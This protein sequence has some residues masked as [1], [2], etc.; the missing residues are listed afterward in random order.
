MSLEIARRIGHRE[1]TSLALAGQ[2]RLLRACG[3]AAGARRVHEEMLETARDLGTSLWT[4]D[5]YGNLGE[6]LLQAG[7]GEATARYIEAAIAN[8]GD[9]MK[10]ALRPLIAQAELHLRAGRAED[11]VAAARHVAALAPEMRVFVADAR[12]VEGEALARLGR[13]EEAITVLADARAIV[14]AI[15]ALPGQWRI[16]LALAGLL[17][18]CGRPDQ[19]RD[20]AAE[21][22]AALQRT[23]RDISDPALRR[24]FQDSN[25]WRE[26]TKKSGRPQEPV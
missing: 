24:R 20:A 2:G 26:A 9:C 17:D 11:A 21:A 23:A 8:A 7:D 5:A 10:Y 15:G 16:G 3:D 6:D 1:W 12:C 4:A 18:R 14:A 19:A 13:L 22:L 25:P